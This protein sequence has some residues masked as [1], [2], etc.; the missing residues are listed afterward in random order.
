MDRILAV[1]RIET[2]RLLIDRPSI[3]LILLVP[4]LQLVLFGYAVNL[5]P[6]NIPIAIAPSCDAQR[7]LMRRAVA[8]T[9]SFSLFPADH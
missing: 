7:D 8:D 3:G 1:A 4:A 6:K 2:L 5:T 9:G